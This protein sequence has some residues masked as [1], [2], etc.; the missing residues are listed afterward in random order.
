MQVLEKQEAEKIIKRLPDNSTFEDIQY[1]LYISKKLQNAR[2]NIEQGDF[3]SEEDVE[4]RLS[5]WIIK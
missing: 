2:L 4:K 3:Y 5:K 1:H